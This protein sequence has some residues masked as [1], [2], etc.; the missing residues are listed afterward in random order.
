MTC[1]KCLTQTP[2][3]VF[4]PF[5][6]E[7]LLGMHNI[8]WKKTMKNRHMCQQQANEE[9]LGIKVKVKKSFFFI[10][11]PTVQLALW[12]LQ[13][14]ESGTSWVGATPG[15][16]RCAWGRT[17]LTRSTVEIKDETQRKMRRFSVNVAYSLT[18]VGRMSTKSWG[19]S[20][21]NYGIP[22]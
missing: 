4:Q 13:W 2:N 21:P 15:R 16:R 10:T 19:I 18:S 8:V 7:C 3:T 12:W 6:T 9:A 20:L 14:G 5:C 11:E 17:C 22:V 1:D